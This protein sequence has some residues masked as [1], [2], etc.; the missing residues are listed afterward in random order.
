MSIKQRMRTNRRGCD[1][2]FI[3]RMVSIT[4][5]VALLLVIGTAIYYYQHSSVE[6]VV[7]SKDTQLMEKFSFEDGII[8]IVRKEDFYQGIYLEKGLL[9]WKEILRSNNILSQNASDDFYSTD[10][11][12]FVPYKNTTLFFGYTPDVDLIKEVK[13]RNES[14]VIRRS[15]T[16]PIWHMKVPMKVTEF[17]ADQLSLVLKDGQEIFY[18]FSESP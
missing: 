6:K 14:Y 2:I 1:Q 5:S 18:P 9:G 8:A 3:K 4:M 13:F 12:A 17:E 11:F 10:L 15:I 16:S 7:S